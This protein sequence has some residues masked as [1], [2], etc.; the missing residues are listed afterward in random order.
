[1]VITSYVVGNSE[2]LVVAD[3]ARQT[4]GL[5]G[6]RKTLFCFAAFVNR[7]LYKLIAMTSL[8]F[9]LLFFYC[10]FSCPSILLLLSFLWVANTF[11]ALSHTF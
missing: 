8:F 4:S 6:K 1:M 11:G 9:F 5:A 10:S 2:V 7:I 3:V